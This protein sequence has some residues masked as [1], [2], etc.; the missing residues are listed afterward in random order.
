MANEPDRFDI[1]HRQ[2]GFAEET[3]ILVDRE[4]R[5]CYLYRWVGNSAGLTV[6]V[7]ADGKP[8]LHKD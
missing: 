3:S 4:T 1:V 6:L 5:V 8:V 2:K 7:D